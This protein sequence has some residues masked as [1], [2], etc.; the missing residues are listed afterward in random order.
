MP[1]IS[2]FGAQVPSYSTILDLDRKMREF[3]VPQ[4]LRPASDEEQY[5]PPWIIMNRWATLSTKES[6]TFDARFLLRSALISA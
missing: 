5:V 2:A 4:H 3:P 6:S 1:S